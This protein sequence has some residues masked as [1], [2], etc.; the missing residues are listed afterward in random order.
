M[1]LV[2]STALAIQSVISNN[3]VLLKS[4]TT[5]P[6]AIRI[7]TNTSRRF[8]SNSFQ[9]H[10]QKGVGRRDREWFSR[11]VAFSCVQ[12][13]KCCTGSGKV[14][15]TKPEIEAMAKQLGISVRNFEEKYIDV[16]SGRSM[17]L[18]DN[19]K[20]TNESCIF[21]TDDN[22][23]TVYAS[24]PI[25]CR[26]YPF[27]PGVMKSFAS[28]TEEAKQCPGID[29]KNTPRPSEALI[30]QK[31]KENAVD[32]A[33]LGEIILTVQGDDGSAVV[34]S[35][36]ELKRVRRLERMEQ[37]ALKR[38][39]ETAASPTQGDTSN[40]IK[41]ENQ[42]QTSSVI[43]NPSNNNNQ[44]LQRVQITQEDG[45]VITVLVPPPK[46]APTALGAAAAT[47]QQHNI[48]SYEEICDRINSILIKRRRD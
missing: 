18:K 39:E 9:L 2:K 37:M 40:N 10:R 16:L 21:L 3:Y 42:Q 35:K 8:H 45:S 44:G 34:M 38:A 4:N 23:C 46:V 20:S 1:I 11:G 7:L 24:R 13:G 5:A 43:S 48:V 6:N 28:W 15:V 32:A 41:T 19:P 17:V 12:C 22:K 33:R 14:V 31:A 36:Q 27:F 26:A 47:Q 30:K 29:V 25:Q